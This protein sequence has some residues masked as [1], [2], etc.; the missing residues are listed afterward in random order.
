MTRFFIYKIVEPNTVANPFR[1]VETVNTI[2]GPRS[3]LTD[4]VFATLADA[5]EGLRELGLAQMERVR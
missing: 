2:D 1:I 3:R 5:R 4:H